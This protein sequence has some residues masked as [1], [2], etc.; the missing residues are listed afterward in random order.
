MLKP[1]LEDPF[2]PHPRTQESRLASHGLGFMA[3]MIAVKARAAE[4]EMDT[5]GYLGL[6]RPR[7][8]CRILYLNTEYIC[9]G[10]TRSQWFA[11]SGAAIK[12]NDLLV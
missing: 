2:Q 12:Q 9:L 4:A 7:K 8:I 5:E 11:T 10:G 1:E 3:I 6:P